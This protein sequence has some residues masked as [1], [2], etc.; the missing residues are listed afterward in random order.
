M[1]NQSEHQIAEI[2]VRLLDDAY[3][4][5]RAAE[6][7]AEAALRVWFDGLA[8]SPRHGVARLWGRARPR[9][10]SR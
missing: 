10:G 4:A 6:M 7:E 3:M 5:W 2:G 9:G 1:T 8:T